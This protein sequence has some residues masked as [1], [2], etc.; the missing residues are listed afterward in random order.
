[1]NDASALASVIT[2]FAK[3]FTSKISPPPMKPVNAALDVLPYCTTDAPMRQEALVALTD[4]T[5]CLRDVASLREEDMQRL[6]EGGMSE[7]DVGGVLGFWAEEWV[8]E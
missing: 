1:M 8:V 2:A 3:S 7:E 5:T 4:Q 6:L